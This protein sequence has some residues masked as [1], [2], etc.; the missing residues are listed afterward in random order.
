MQTHRKPHAWIREQRS[1]SAHLPDPTH[2]RTKYPRSGK[3]LTP[4]CVVRCVC[5]VAL[6]SYAWGVA[7]LLSKFLMESIVLNVPNVEFVNMWKCELMKLWNFDVVSNV[8]MLQSQTLTVCLCLQFQRRMLCVNT[9]W[10]VNKLK[11]W[12]A[13]LKCH[14]CTCGTYNKHKNTLIPYTSEAI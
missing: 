7:R 5:I 2:A 11:V 13:T 10:H 9:N 14:W 12:T 4:T 8:N 3:P 6:L 1:K